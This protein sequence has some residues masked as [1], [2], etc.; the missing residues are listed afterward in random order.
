MI[1]SAILKIFGSCLTK[2]KQL[3]CTY[4]FFQEQQKYEKA[5]LVDFE[6]EG[7]NLLEHNVVKHVQQAYV[8]AEEK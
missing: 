6:S 3:G 2:A 7:F 1:K 8:T 5:T 4:H